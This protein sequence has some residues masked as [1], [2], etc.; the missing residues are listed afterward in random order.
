MLLSTRPPRLH[1]V[2]AQDRAHILRAF[3]Q[4][5]LEGTFLDASAAY[6]SG[7]DEFQLTLDEPMIWDFVH[8]FE[9][10]RSETTI[11]QSKLDEELDLEDLIQL[12]RFHHAIVEPLTERYSIWALA[13]LCSA[14]QDYP[15]SWTEKV[16]IQRALYR[17]Q[18][19]WFAGR[20]AQLETIYSRAPGAP[21][22]S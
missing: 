10:K 19:L 18:P 21:P 13:A 2:Y 4:Q 9:K 17:F 20:R 16:R 22:H 3:V 11:T 8:D 14:P 6:R 1:S 5:S 7:T 12:V 15:L